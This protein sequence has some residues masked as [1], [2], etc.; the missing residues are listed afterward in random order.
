[1]SVLK[2]LLRKAVLLVCLVLSIGLTWL[3]ISS[4]WLN[5][6][7]EQGGGIW[8]GI[9]ASKGRVAIMSFHYPQQPDVWGPIELHVGDGSS[10]ESRP[11]EDDW[12]ADLG[13]HRFGTWG[14]AYLSDEFESLGGAVRVWNLMFPAWLPVTVL[15]PAP[16]LWIR[17]AL[18]RSRRSKRGLCQRCGYD[19]R[20]SPD[21][22]PECGLRLAVPA[23]AK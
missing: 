22:C 18:V 23:P 2:Q 7:V 11:L 9:V 17:R 12:W 16:L 21:R 3:W 13:A 1:M 5:Y 4:Y 10:F 8:R 19:L 6:R 20:A 14:F 15:L